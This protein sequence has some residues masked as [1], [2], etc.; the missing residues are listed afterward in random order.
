M[1]S[2]YAP[3]SGRWDLKPGNI[4]KT[5]QG[6]FLIPFQIPGVPGEWY[7]N[8]PSLEISALPSICASGVITDFGFG[9][10]CQLA[11]S[12]HVLGFPL[13]KLVIYLND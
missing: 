6:A 13:T 3:V 2:P 9:A 4:A 8:P 5:F 12:E 7:L 10:V 1:P 11:P